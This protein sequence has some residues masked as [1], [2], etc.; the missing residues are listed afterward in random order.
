MAPLSITLDLDGIRTN[1][2][3]NKEVGHWPGGA[4]KRK[5][6]TSP[7]HTHPPPFDSPESRNLTSTTD[8]S[9]AVRTVPSPH[10]H[11]ARPWKSRRANIIATVDSGYMSDSPPMARRGHRTQRRDQSASG[12]RLHH[13]GYETDLP[14]SPT[15]ARLASGVTTEELR[16]GSVLRLS[17]MLQPPPSPMEGSDRMHD[18]VV[19]F[20]R[21][22]FMEDTW[23]WKEF[24]REHARVGSLSNVELLRIY[25][26]AQEQLDYWVDSR[27]PKHLNYKKVEIVSFSINFFFAACHDNDMSDC[28]DCGVRG[29]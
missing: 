28:V 27:L 21:E 22:K 16:R 25:W 24:T 11:Y 17:S 4:R 26:F 18:K 10:E 14:L 9:A 15:R 12:S 29:D 7:S 3:N 2:P 8:A 19:S 5:R 13:S 23:D 20:L 6:E 1:P